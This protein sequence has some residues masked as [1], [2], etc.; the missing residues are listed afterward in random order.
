MRYAGHTLT[1]RG[2]SV[3]N[4]RT[5][6]EI[7]ETQPARDV[8]AAVEHLYDEALK[9]WRGECHMAERDADMADL[10]R[11]RLN[12]HLPELVD[13]L[14]SHIEVVDAQA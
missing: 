13:L 14:P 4:V 3:E 1:Q 12:L 11:T 6:R 9:P 8:I 2:D 7:C 10:L 5:L